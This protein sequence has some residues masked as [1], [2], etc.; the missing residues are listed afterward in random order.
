MVL[1]SPT[2]GTLEVNDEVCEMLGYERNELLQMTFAQVTHPDDLAANLALA[3]RL[4]P[5]NRWLFP[6]QAVYSQGRQAHLR[7]RFCEMRASCG[8]F[9]RL[10][11]F[12]GPGR[13]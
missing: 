5:G 9:D 12:A 2:K 3:N 13:H 1:S 6:G 4:L 11:R 8:R 7:H 10:H